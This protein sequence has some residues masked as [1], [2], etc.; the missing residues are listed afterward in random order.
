[1]Q[2]SSSELQLKA[3]RF[4]N[5]TVNPIGMLI[6]WED[7]CPNGVNRYLVH[8]TEGNGEP[9]Y[10]PINVCDTKT[11]EKASQKYSR[12]GTEDGPAGQ[13]R[14]DHWVQS[15]FGAAPRRLMEEQDNI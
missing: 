14:R 7:D 2:I 9:L 5:S 8:I 6:S 1:M 13:G 10:Q 3:F 15:K 11:C 12:N 4:Q